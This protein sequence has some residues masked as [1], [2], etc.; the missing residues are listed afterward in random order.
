[1]PE[2]ANFFF[3]NIVK[4]FGIPKI[5]LYDNDSRFTSKFWKALWKLLGTKAC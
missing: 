1:M 4:L 2:C 3:S 5:A